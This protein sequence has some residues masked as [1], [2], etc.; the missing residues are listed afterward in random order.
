MATTPNKALLAIVT[1]PMLSKASAEGH[2]NALLA[3]VEEG[4][5]DRLDAW[6]RM[7]FFEKVAEAFKSDTTKAAVTAEVG[8]QSAG[9]GKVVK[10][11]GTFA[12]RSVGTTF[13]Y[14]HDA[15]WCDLRDA[16]EML[17]ELKARREEYL[18]VL[19]GATEEKYRGEKL[20]ILPATKVSRDGFA[21]SMNKE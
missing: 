3:A 13:Q 6:A 8:K 19:P 11:Y 20:R 4:Q 1:T 18:K 14:D 9:T 12:T 10:P 5:V 2:A 15:E 21:F 16:L 17:K 7:D